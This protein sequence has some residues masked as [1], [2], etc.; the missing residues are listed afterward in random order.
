M[1][2][3]VPRVLYY[4]AAAFEDIDHS[5][6]VKDSMAKLRERLEKRAKDREN[7]QG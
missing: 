2:Q 6:V 5:G 1:V 7:Q 4:Q 3:L